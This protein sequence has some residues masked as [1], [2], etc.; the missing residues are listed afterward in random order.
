MEA[1]KDKVN[2]VQYFNIG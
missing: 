2:Q 1:V